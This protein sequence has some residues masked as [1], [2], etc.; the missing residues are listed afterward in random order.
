M[1]T[2]SAL[3]A[4]CAGNSP[5]PGEFPAQRPVT[6]SFDVFFDLRLNKR[7]SK[8]SWGWWFETL[9]RPLWRQRNGNDRWDVIGVLLSIPWVFVHA[10]IILL[11][12]L[13]C[14]DPGKHKTLQWRHNG[15]DGVS[16]HQPQECLIN[17]LFKR[18][19]KKTPKLRATGLCTGNSPMTGEFPAQMVSNAEN[20]SIWWRHHVLINLSKG[21]KHFEPDCWN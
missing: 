15:C 9:S 13:W 2:F 17:R 20:V 16:N 10:N 3:L 1:E 19:S 8:Q 12:P 5:V 4:I 7:L 18:R 6:Q 11:S 14:V 21:L